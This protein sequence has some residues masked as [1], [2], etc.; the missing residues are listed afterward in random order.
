MPIGI[1]VRDGERETQNGAS[2][3]S[4]V[5]AEFQDAEPFWELTLAPLH[6]GTYGH[7]IATRPSD[8]RCGSTNIRYI[9]RA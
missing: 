8:R 4:P 1:M 5:R 2:G 3:D 7:R 9:N 6:P